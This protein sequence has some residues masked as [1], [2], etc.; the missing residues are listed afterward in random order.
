MKPV[1]IISLILLSV[2]L[3]M[4]A[5][6]DIINQKLKAS[7]E[8]NSGINTEKQDSVSNVENVS[9]TPYEYNV[10]IPLTDGE[11]SPEY[12]ISINL[13]TAESDD[14]SIAESINKTIICQILDKDGAEIKD[15]VDSFVKEEE[16]YYSDMKSYY[17]NER[18]VI[19][20]DEQ[21]NYYCNITSSYSNNGDGVINYK[22]VNDSYKGG[23]HGSYVVTLLNFDAATGKEITLG[24]LIK[25]GSED[26]LSDAL[27]SALIKQKGVK[28]K[29]ALLDMGYFLEDGIYPSLNFTI[30]KDSITFYYNAY[31][32]ASYSTGHTEITLSKQELKNILK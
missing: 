9:F 12:K 17:I 5:S 24:D 13:Q 23:A 26:E 15:A 1:K 31:D 16:L 28:G 27:M 29:E 7:K 11:K 2:C 20:S 25:E 22:S 14:K 8:G 19:D 21:F 10:K 4:L 3:A 6:C 18:E 30:G 32:I